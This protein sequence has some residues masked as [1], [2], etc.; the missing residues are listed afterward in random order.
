MEDV[1]LGPSGDFPVNTLIT[2]EQANPQTIYLSDGRIIIVWHSNDPAAD[3]D[4]F[5]IRAQIFDASGNRIGGEFLINDVA[6]R[7]QTQPDV[8]VL[9]NGQFVVT[10][11]EGAAR[12][13]GSGDYIQARL[14]NS[15]GSAVGNSFTVSEPSTGGAISPVITA[16]PNGGFAIGWHRLD[17]VNGGNRIQIFAADGTSIGNEFDPSIDGGPD[18]YG[19]ALS[20]MSDGRI[21]AVWVQSGVGVIGRIIG[22]DGQ[23][24]SESLLLGNNG[25]E[26]FASPAVVGLTNGGFALAWRGVSFAGATAINEDFVQTFDANGNSTSAL[27]PLV[28]DG[29]AFGSQIVANNDGGFTIVASANNFSSAGFMAFRFDAVANRIGDPILITG[30]SGFVSSTPTIAISPTGEIVATWSI[31]DPIFDRELNG[32]RAAILSYNPVPNDAPEI[33]SNGGEEFVL[34]N[35]AENSNIVTTV[36]AS[37]ADGNILA[38]SIIGGEDAALFQIDP[39]TGLLR[40]RTAPDFETP[41]SASGTNVYSVIVAADDGRL[42]DTQSILIEVTNIR[43]GATINGTRGNDEVDARHSVR[44][45]P[46]PGGGEDTIFGFGGD[47]ELN[48]LGGNDLIDGG[49]GDDE[50]FGGSGDDDLRGGSGNDRLTGGVGIDVLAGGAGRDVFAFRNVNDSLYGSSDVILD[51]NSAQRDRID[52]SSI[53]ADANTRG[54][55]AFTFIGDAVFNGIAG[56]LRTDFG[57]D[58]NGEQ[59]SVI[60]GD[61][62]GDGVADFEIW[63]SA[64]LDLVVT[65]FVL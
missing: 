43:E 38:Y 36:N 52:V 29:R 63:L 20:T 5:G 56:E 25:L 21:V 42:G 3:G 64:Q 31:D 49:T 2:G 30:T 10:W 60:Q 45:Q 34:L 37:D 11:L 15:D 39:H 40:F 46:R 23:Q 44:G 4:G 51:F 32:I 17:D 65:D 41:S 9:A 18:I 12:G 59:N 58:S 6:S 62:D 14:F 19:L 16:L 26:A 57:F 48:G 22:T 24:D 27:Q 8:T 1:D 50:L 7:N 28:D 35:V 13:D 33:V 47:D 53:D 54:N 55:Q 61:V